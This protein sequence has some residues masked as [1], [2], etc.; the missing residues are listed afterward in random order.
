ICQLARVKLSVSEKQVA[1]TGKWMFFA[2]AFPPQ[3]ERHS[4][5]DNAHGEVATQLRLPTLQRSDGRAIIVIEV[6]RD[7][8][9]LRRSRQVLAPDI[10]LVLTERDCRQV[11]GSPRNASVVCELLVDTEGFRP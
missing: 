8:R 1:P 3:I 10:H 5:S 2:V 4:V 11:T 7:F 6:G 9:L